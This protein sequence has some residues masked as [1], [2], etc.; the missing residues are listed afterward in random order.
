MLK[1]RRFRSTLTFR[2]REK[3]FGRWPVYRALALGMRRANLYYDAVHMQ[4]R[5]ALHTHCVVGQDQ[6]IS[7]FDSRAVSN[8]KTCLK[9]QKPTYLYPFFWQPRG[10]H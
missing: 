9:Q 10:Y 1:W 2:W 4:R 8:V 6:D 3:S 7:N 5:P